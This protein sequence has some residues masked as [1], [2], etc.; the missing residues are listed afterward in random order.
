MQKIIFLVFLIVSQGTV[1]NLLQTFGESC[2]PA[3]NVSSLLDVELIPIPDTISFQRAPTYNGMG[4][5][6]YS[7][8]PLGYLFIQNEAVDN[9]TVL[10]IGAGF[11]NIAV[12]CL[13]KLM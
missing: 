10:E 6:F 13:K 5:I 3:S 4:Y 2:I 8:S 1:A 9:R 12:E 7:I 11:S